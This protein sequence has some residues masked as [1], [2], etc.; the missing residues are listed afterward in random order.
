MMEDGSHLRDIDAIV[1]CTGFRPDYSWL[2]LPAF[3]LDGHPIHE[4]GL[5]TG[6]RGLGFVGMRH[7][8]RFR[9][10]LLGG[11]GEDADHVV[12]GLVGLRHRRIPG[13]GSGVA[14]DGAELPSN[15]SA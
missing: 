15:L 13:L 6:V 8:S 9:S 12:A 3:G 10:A 5:A 2:E 4:R 7:Q 14:V 11:V 1:W